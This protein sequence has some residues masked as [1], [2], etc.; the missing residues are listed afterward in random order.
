[1]DFYH[2]EAQLLG[3]DSL[4]ITFEESAETLRRLTPGIEAGLYLPPRVETFPLAEAPRLY[5]EPPASRLKPIL[6]P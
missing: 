6:V 2:N 3:L 4:K 1:M 5:R